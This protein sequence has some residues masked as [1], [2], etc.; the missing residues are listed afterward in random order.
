VLGNL[1]VDHGLIRMRREEAPATA[2]VRALHCGPLPEPNRF[3]SPRLI[4][5]LRHH[6]PVTFWIAALTS[7]NVVGVQ[8]RK[9]V[10]RFRFF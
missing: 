5:P 6:R 4:G 10:R 1:G 2:E 9:A 3:M 7:S 8:P